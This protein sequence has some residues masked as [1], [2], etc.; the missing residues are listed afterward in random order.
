MGIHDGHRARMKKEFLEGGLSAFS[1]LRAL[2]LLL[3]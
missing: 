1:D 2:E 3:F